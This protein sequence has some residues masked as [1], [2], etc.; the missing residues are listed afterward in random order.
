MDA[1]QRH[2]G[3]DSA[4]ETILPGEKVRFENRSDYQQYGRLHHAISDAGHRER[5]LTTIGL[6]Y[7]HAQQGLGLIRLR[8]QLLLQSFQPL[9]WTRRFDVLETLAIYPRRTPIAAAAPVGFGENIVT[10]HLVPQAVEPRGRFVLGF[11]L[12]RRL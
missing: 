8:L 2:L 1:T 11:R 4:S 12:Q 7:P 3:I 5:A 10:E 6:G 9:A